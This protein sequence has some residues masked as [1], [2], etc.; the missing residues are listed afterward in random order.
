MNH[1]NLADHNWLAHSINNNSLRRH[2]NLLHGAVIDLGCGKTP[3]KTDILKVADSYVGVDWI[4]SLHDMAQVDVCTDLSRRFPFDDASFDA[5]VSFQVMEHIAEPSVFLFEC[6]RILKPGG[7][8]LLTVP[9]MWHVHEAPHDYYRYTSYGLEHILKKAGFGSVQVE[10]NTGFWQMFVLKF[11]YHTFKYPVPL[12]WFFIP[13]WLVGQCLA[14]LLDYY[15]RQVVE[16]AS[17]TVL[18]R[19]ALVPLSKDK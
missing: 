9:F 12:R 4:N 15:F 18:A 6:N 13:I 11:N 10:A 14:P 1:I 3:Y 8:F 5:A 17:Y 2:L 19:K 16:T 7:I